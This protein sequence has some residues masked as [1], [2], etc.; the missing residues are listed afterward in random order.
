MSSI[1][2]SPSAPKVTPLGAESALRR[3]ILY[4]LYLGAATLAVLL[5]LELSLRLF[6][7]LP[8]GLFHYE[9]F[10]KGTLF[11]PDTEMRMV[12]GP[13]PYT[14][15]TNRHGLRGPDIP[16]EKPAGTTRII[17]LGDSVTHGFYV[18]NEHTYPE[19]LEQNLRRDGYT[20]DVINIAR[21]FAS[22]DME[23]AML[24]K[25]GMKLAP[26]IVVLTFVT[27]DIEEIA[28]KSREQ[29]LHHDLDHPL[30]EAQSEWFLFGRTAVGELL[31]DS[32]MKWRYPKYR[33]HARE[34]G[35]TDDPEITI[36]DG[37]HFRRNAEHFL[38]D[39][40]KKY[41]SFA[42]YESFSPE[43]QAVVDDYL[44]ALEQLKLYCDEQ[45]LVLVFSYHPDYAHLYLPE[46][47]QPLYDQL[48]AACA[49]LGIP[50]ADQVPVFR[51]H[52]DEVLHFAP[53]DYHPNAAGNALIAEAVQ[54]TLLS[55][56]LLRHDE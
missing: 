48:K 41:N 25:Y 39:F 16:L 55:K 35:A 17:A 38:N 24:K 9:P 23:F 52:A 36:E 10:D 12:M 31:L 53:V 26:D 6:F 21:G 45:G 14:I 1:T 27:N 43:Q 46:R 15:K 20:V 5:F 42:W 33:K 56:G 50:F 37:D 4:L 7:G 22:I 47:K 32:M 54:D 19:L 51:A 2:P 40:A 29:L 18:P 13:M 3:A 49:R 34:L 11:L 30:P 28:G 8:E 44:W